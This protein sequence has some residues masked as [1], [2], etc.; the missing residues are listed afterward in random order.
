MNLV[1]NR[2]HTLEL[3]MVFFFIY[4]S[5][6]IIEVGDLNTKI[7]FIGNIRICQPIEL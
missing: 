6:I 3:N 1:Y 5:K 2:N 7:F 4:N